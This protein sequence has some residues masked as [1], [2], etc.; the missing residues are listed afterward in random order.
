MK[1]L[2]FLLVAIVSLS[3]CKTLIPFTEDLKNSNSWTDNEI[4]Q[5]Q[6]YNSEPI[7]LNRQL[8]SNETG[9]VSGKIKMV[10]GKEVEEIVIRKGTP[11][12]ISALPDGSRMA[13]SFEI[14]DDH[15]LTFGVDKNRGGRYY[16]R[17]KDYKK[18]K[19]AVVSYFNKTYNV[20]PQALTA[21]LQ[22]NLKK[23]K[24]EQLSLRVAKGR[25]L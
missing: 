24:K 5:I 4:K 9:I 18:N 15:Y 10:D 25:K 7:I 2:V 19:F 13:I 21:Y 8:K 16:L 17:L 11:G 14:G 22:V 23:I 12:I 3:S 1:N 6:Y 20:S